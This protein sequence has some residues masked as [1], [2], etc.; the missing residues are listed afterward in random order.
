MNNLIIFCAVHAK[1]KGTLRYFFALI[2]LGVHL[3][4][5]NNTVYSFYYLH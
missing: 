4:L 3:S 5:K 1:K 2:S